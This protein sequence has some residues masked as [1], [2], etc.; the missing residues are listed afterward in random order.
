MSRFYLGLV[1]LAPAAAAAPA[2]LGQA[3]FASGVPQFVEGDFRT[4]TG[5]HYTATGAALGAPSPVVGAD[6]AFAGVLSPFNSHY[7][8]GE[9]VGFGRG[10]GITLEFARP[11]A[12][13]GAPQ[14]GVFTNAALVDADYP[15]GSAGATARTYAADEYGERTAVVE[16]ASDPSDFRSLGRV[17]FNAPTNAFADATGPYQYPTPSAS[18]TAD[19]ATPFTRPLSAF[20]G[21]DF[22]GA[23]E[24]LGGSAGGTWLSVPLDLGLDEIRYVRL[25]DPKWLLADGRL[26][27]EQPSRYLS[28]PS[29]IKPADLF[30]DAAVLVPEPAG[31][32]WAFVAAGAAMLRRRRRS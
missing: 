26:V 3:Q 24:V 4:F 30:V 31:V 20:D 6:T 18:P 8:T 29:F 16:V 14:V 22:A 13:T 27:D 25:S 32:A 19:F 10:G 17:V 9:L 2:A 7:D 21:K 12:V 23:L 5:T 15:A 1:V 28:D 11:A